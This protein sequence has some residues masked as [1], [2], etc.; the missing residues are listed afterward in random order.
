M[1]FPVAL[2]GAPVVVTVDWCRG[3]QQGDVPTVRATGKKGKPYCVSCWDPHLK[4]LKPQERGD[5]SVA[6]QNP[7]D[8]KA[9]DPYE[10]ESKAQEPDFTRCKHPECYANW[11]KAKHYSGYCSLSCALASG[12]VEDGDA[13]ARCKHPECHANWRK[14]KHYSG[15]CSLSCAL[16]S[17]WVEDVTEKRMKKAKY[18][19]SGVVVPPPH[20]MSAEISQEIFADEMLANKLVHCQMEQDIERKK[21]TDVEAVQAKNDNHGLKRR[22]DFAD[23]MMANKMVRCQMELYIA[24]NKGTDVEAVQAKNDKRGLGYTKKGLDFFNKDSKAGSIVFV[25]AGIL[26]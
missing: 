5:P 26:Q 22:L 24:R 6:A 15:Y 18:S 3:C 10:P 14:A 16:A 20:S 17:G 12:W 1:V 7:A 13:F 21:E 25:S 19:S 2:S 23:E 8:L 9:P 4:L 11:R